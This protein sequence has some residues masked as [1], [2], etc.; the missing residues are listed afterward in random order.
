MAFIIQQLTA[1]ATAVV[2]PTWQDTAHKTLAEARR[3]NPNEPKGFFRRK[4][5]PDAPVSELESFAK[6]INPRKYNFSPKFGAIL[7]AL[8]GYDYGIRD[9]RGG[10]I[11]GVSVTSDGFVIGRST[12]S[13]GGGA[14]LGDVK[15]LRSN[16]AEFLKH[17]R[18]TD[19]ERLRVQYLPAQLTAGLPLLSSAY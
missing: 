12:A 10:H 17:L 2:T 13:D 1:G 3:L 9:G 4:D 11:T 14:F 18:V 8:I 7:G 5:I 19:A 15:D 6:R 16:L